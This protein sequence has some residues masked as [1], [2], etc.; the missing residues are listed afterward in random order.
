MVN[1]LKNV[2]RLLFLPPGW[3][4]VFVVLLLS[5]LEFNAFLAVIVV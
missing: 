1:S 3:V 2:G 4:V 5:K